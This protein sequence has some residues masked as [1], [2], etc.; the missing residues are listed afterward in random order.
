[1]LTITPPFGEHVRQRMAA[2]LKRRRHIEAK[3]VLQNRDRHVRVG[4]ELFDTTGVL[5]HDVQSVESAD[6][7]V[8]DVLETVDVGDVEQDHRRLSAAGTDLVVLARLESS[9]GGR[10]APRPL[11]HGRRPARYLRPMPF[12]CTGDEGGLPV[13]PELRS[14]VGFYLGHPAVRP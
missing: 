14:D 4:A 2:E 8:D 12:S 6:G 1:M 11:P 9:L 13:Q 3:R 5:H 10:R 7:F